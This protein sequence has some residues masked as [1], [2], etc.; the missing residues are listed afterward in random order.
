MYIPR[1]NRISDMDAMLAF[2]Q[3]NNFAIVISA[4]DPAPLASHV[5]LTMQRNGEELRI[6]THL[7]KA[8]PHWQSITQG[9]TLIIFSG[10]HAYISPRHY[11]AF[12]SV[13]TWN[14]ITVHAYGKARLIDF[15]A[16]PEELETMLLEI[17]D[18]HEPRY[19]DQWAQLSQRYKDGMKQGIVGVEIEVTR[20]EG[21]A[22]LSQNKTAEEQERIAESL[23]SHSDGSVVQVGYAMKHG[24]L[25]SP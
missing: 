1:L 13:P 23:L 10:P 3:R 8:N 14:Y 22:K 9:E 19:A 2:M 16:Q 11:D 21:K 17:I 12:E 7:A 18:A 4:A 20:L 15:E 24:Q 25:I 5:P 6:R